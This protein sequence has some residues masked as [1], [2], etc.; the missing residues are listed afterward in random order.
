MKDPAPPERPEEKATAP[1]IRGF[2]RIRG[3]LAGALAEFLGLLRQCLHLGPDEGR[4]QLEHLLDVLG[5]HQLLGEVERGRD[6]LLDKAHRLPAHVLG[7]LAGRFGLPFQC[8]GGALSRRNEAFDRLLGL[9]YALLGDGAHLRRNLKLLNHGSLLSQLL[10]ESARSFSRRRR[11]IPAA[12][13]LSFPRWP[14]NYRPD[15]FIDGIRPF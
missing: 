2:Q 5:T 8:A 1:L 6:V 15:R 4:L 13:R 9:L 10:L 7:A 12:I 3:H 14:R 11:W